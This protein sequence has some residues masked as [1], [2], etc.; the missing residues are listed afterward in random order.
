MLQLT[1]SAADFIRATR[2]QQGYS[3]D[4]ALRIERRPDDLSALQLGFAEA[5]R[6]DDRVGE[7]EGVPVFVS[8]DVAPELDDK[9]LD[10]QL[11][12]DGASL[13]LRDS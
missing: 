7:T 10:V 4:V 9:L 5:P 8:A 3:D 11:T 12:P 6:V 1:T 2:D 13:V